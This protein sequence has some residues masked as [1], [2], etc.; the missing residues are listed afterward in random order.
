MAFRLVRD[1]RDSDVIN[2]PISSLTVVVGDMLQL[3]V[4]ATTWT[5]ATSTTNHFAKKAVATEAAS[6]SDTEVTALVVSNDQLWDVDLANASASADD[7]D[8]MVLT[9]ENTVNNTGTDSAAQ[10]A[11]F[12]QKSPVGVAA[13]NRSLGWFVEGTGIDP[14]A[15]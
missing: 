12:I 14:D 10:V 7:G 5:L 2:L 6:T 15:T 11:V 1:A 9:D 4:G 13:D 3:L 8:R